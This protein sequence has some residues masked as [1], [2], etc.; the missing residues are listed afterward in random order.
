VTTQRVNKPQTYRFCLR[1]SQSPTYY[2]LCRY[3]S[4]QGWVS[5][6][7]N[8]LAHFSEK[9]FEF[10][11]AAAECLE[12]K[13]LL[14]Q[15]V[16]QFCPQVMPVTY[17]INDQNW[18]L[19]LN[20]IA[21]EQ[22]RQDNQLV[23]QIDNLAWIL[24]PALLNNGQHI[25]I[26]QKLSQLEQHF[27]SSN[28]LGGEHVLQH[29]QI[30][31]HLLKGPQLGHKYS[32]RMF[33][34][35]TNYAGAYLYP[36]GYF[37]VGLHPYQPNDFTD[38]RPHLT[39]EHLRDDELNVVQIRT[40]QYDLFKPFYPQIK[41]IVSSIIDGV[42]HLYPQAFIKEQQET[43]AIFGF[44]FIV[45]HDMRVW[46]LEANHAPCFPL[47]DDH[48]LQKSLYSDFWQAIITRF[49]FPMANKQAVESIVYHPFEAVGGQS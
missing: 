15:L 14:A 18:P 29:Y 39:N 23:D 6:K 10:L 7:F 22:Y 43:L 41:T 25:N 24:K 4:E 31:P 36:Q 37:N 5:T 45:N 38:I 33:V 40:Q 3:L 19:V 1:A 27:L 32:I 12:Y 11:L 21:D 2:N 46:L 9:N 44:D 17:C 49:I 8:W 48:P 26:F 20:Q 16:A 35:L 47:S 13:H 34:V 30:Q 28:R 42:Q